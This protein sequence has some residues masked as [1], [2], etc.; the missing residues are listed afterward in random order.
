M[1]R[2]ALA[3]CL[4]AGCAAHG[5]HLRV[6]GDPEIDC[7]KPAPFFSY[8]IHVVFQLGSDA[9]LK[10]AEELRVKAYRYFAPYFGG[11]PVC[12]DQGDGNGGRYDNGELCMIKDH[13]L[14]EILKVG[15]FPSGEWSMFVPLPHLQLVTEWF[16]QNRGE[17]DFLVHPNSGCEYE[18]HGIW[19]QWSGTA[20]PLNMDIFE[21]QTQTNEW[22]AVRGD[23]ANPSCIAA[24]ATCGQAHP[25][26]WANSGAILACCEGTTCDCYSSGGSSGKCQCLGLE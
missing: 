23:N 25:S 14:P 7:T 10:A 26:T 17:L 5:G 12:P 11:S 15:P 22:A 24:N 3:L 13:K 19:A 18:D 2:L 21:E 1:L 6:K 20:W 4:L 16:L 8:H 9:K